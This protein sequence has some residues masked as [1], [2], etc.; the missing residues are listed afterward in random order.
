MAWQWCVCQLLRFY[1]LE[2]QK[3]RRRLMIITGVITL[4]TS[5]VFWQVLVAANCRLMPRAVFTGSSSQ[6][7]QPPLRS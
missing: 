7:L 4:V 3:S 1:P 6:I 5:V 2:A